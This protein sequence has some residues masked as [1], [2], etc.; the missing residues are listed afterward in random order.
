MA[1]TQGSQG[2]QGAQGAQGIQGPQART[3][4]L[5]PFSNT[6]VRAREARPALE[7]AILALREL[8]VRKVHK[9]RKAYKDRKEHR[10]A[11]FTVKLR[12]L[13]R[14]LE[15]RPVQHP[16]RTCSKSLRSSTRHWA[17]A[18]RNAK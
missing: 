16:T 10:Y 9:E 12:V 8:K 14:A 6:Q 4:S 17:R 2:A 13:R 11:R 5:C 7:E 15:A 3:K 18:R 1:G